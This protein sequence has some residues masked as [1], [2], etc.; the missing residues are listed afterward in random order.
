MIIY[1]AVGID[2]LNYK[3]GGFE[4][5][6]GGETHTV[7]IDGT[8]WKEIT[9]KLANRTDNYVASD[10]GSGNEYIMSYVVTFTQEM[11]ELLKDETVQIRAFL[12]D[13]SGNT[14]YSTTWNQGSL[15]K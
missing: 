8:V 6:I 1:M 13:F 9:V 4:V 10:F 3:E 5:T 11:K 7:Y 15:V 12:T 14:I 2:S